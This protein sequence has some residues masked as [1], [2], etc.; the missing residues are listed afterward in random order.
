MA[1]SGLAW[2]RAHR[3]RAGALGVAGPTPR[4]TV[5]H[6]ECAGHLEDGGNPP[7]RAG[8]VKAEQELRLGGA[9]MT[10][11]ASGGPRRSATHPAS[12]RERGR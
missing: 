12:R 2:W 1:R 11:M 7:D 4:V 3:Q 6:R 5:L 10:P 9:L 8:D